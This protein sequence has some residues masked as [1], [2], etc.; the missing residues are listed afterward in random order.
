MSEKKKGTEK[1]TPRRGVPHRDS[2]V[3]YREKIP[4]ELIHIPNAAKKDHEAWSAGRNWANFPAPYRL[5]NCGSVNSSKTNTTKN[6]ILRA[7][8]PFKKITLIHIA[9]DDPEYDDIDISERLNYCPPPEYFDHEEKQL[10]IIEDMEFKKGDRNVSALFRYV[11]T[12]K[13]VS[14]ILNY[15]NWTTCD[16]IIRRCLSVVNLWQMVDKTVQEIVGKKVGLE[17]SQL[18]EMFDAVCKERRDFLCIDLTD[19]SPCKYR[20]NIWKPIKMIET[21]VLPTKKWLGR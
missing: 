17:N 15:Q 8:P 14:V 18:Q 16:P 5:M 13:N 19:N 12:H 7:Y 6:I 21:P 9:D 3:K 1:V 10:V 11:S 20:L 2:R 4:N